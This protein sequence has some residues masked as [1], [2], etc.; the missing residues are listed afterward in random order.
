MTFFGEDI[1]TGTI[2]GFG[3]ITTLVTVWGH[4]LCNPLFE[5]QGLVVFWNQNFSDFRQVIG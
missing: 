5:N 2:L 3:G 1:L 4:M